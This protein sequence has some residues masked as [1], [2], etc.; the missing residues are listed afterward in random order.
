VAG[1]KQEYADRAMELLHKGVKA[2]Y[3]DAAHMGWEPALTSLRER[4]DFKR[5]LA[6]LAKSLPVK[7]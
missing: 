7:N 1:K 4:D 6:E 5:L 3:D 2:G